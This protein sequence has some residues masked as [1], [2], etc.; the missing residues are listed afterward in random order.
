MKSFL[1]GALSVVL[2]AGLATQSSV[3]LANFEDEELPDPSTLSDEEKLEW[4]KKLYIQAKE[5]HDNEDYYNS[6]I[7][8]EQAYS[9]APDKHVFA[10]NLGVDAWELKDCARVKQYLQLFLIKDED[11]EDLQADAREILKKADNNPECIT[12]GPGEPDPGPGGG[13]PDPGTKAAPVDTDEPVLTAKNDDSSATDSDKKGP[14]GLLIGGAVLAVLG[15][16]AL[17]GGV[18]TTIVGKGAADE[19]GTLSTPGST[20]FVNQGYDQSI[21]DMENKLSTMNTV[22]PILIGVGG[23]LLAGGIAMIVVDVMNKKKGKGHYANN[24][25]VQLSGLGLAPSQG[26]ASASLSLRF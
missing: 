10:Y 18:G 9:Y 26:G 23:A 25:K 19:L 4:A 20:G 21:V 15:A 8:Y 13:D 12:G 14:S 1:R 16:G 22:S 7:K 17:G 5:F 3:A 2:C 24:Q 11:N 6:V